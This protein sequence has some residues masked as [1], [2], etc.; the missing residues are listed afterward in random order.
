[1]SS[2]ASGPQNSIAFFEGDLA[3]GSAAT[4]NPSTSVGRRTDVSAVL[5]ADVDGDGYGDTSQDA[6]PT[7]ASTAGPCFLA[8][9][10]GTPPYTKLTKKPKAEVKTR[11]AKAKVKVRFASVPAGASFQCKLDKGK[12]KACKSPQT[13]KLKPG[14]HKIAVRAVQGGQT[15]PTPAEVAFR[16]VKQ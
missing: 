11:K 4:F 5:E 10:P 12:F 6:C 13:Y 7:D 9:P 15:D 16:V 14:Q 1:V 2:G 8:A 3:A